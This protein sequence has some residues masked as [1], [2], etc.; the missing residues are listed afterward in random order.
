LSDDECNKL[1]GKITQKILFLKYMK[2]NKSPGSDGLTADFFFF[3]TL[4]MFL[5][6]EQSMRDIVKKIITCIPNRKK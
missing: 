2:I 4:G 6:S 1:E 3:F 5:L